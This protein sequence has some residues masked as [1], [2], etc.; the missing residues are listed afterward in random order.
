MKA[1]MLVVFHVF[2]WLRLRWCFFYCLFGVLGVCVVCVLFVRCFLAC[3][4]VCVVLFRC[5]C[6]GLSVCSFMRV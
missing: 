6:C 5:C 3:L 4:F 2:V 1:L